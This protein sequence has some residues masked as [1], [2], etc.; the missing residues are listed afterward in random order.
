MKNNISRSEGEFCQS[1]NE[2]GIEFKE[3]NMEGLNETHC[4]T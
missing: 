2:A 3:F 4:Y 1:G